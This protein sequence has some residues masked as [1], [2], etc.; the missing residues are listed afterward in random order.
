MSDIRDDTRAGFAKIFGYEPHGLWSA[1]GELSLLGDDSDYAEGHVL[2]IA[3]DRR[4]V[5]AAG[6]SVRK[7]RCPPKPMKSLKSH[8]ITSSPTR[9]TVGPLTP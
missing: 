3:I 4:T 1:P 9:S 8:S 6:V 2:S 7:R 5:V